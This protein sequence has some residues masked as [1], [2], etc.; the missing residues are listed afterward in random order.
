MFLRIFAV[1]KAVAK[2]FAVGNGGS[3]CAEVSAEIFWQFSGVTPQ[4]VGNLS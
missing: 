1:S 2:F 4:S 3:D